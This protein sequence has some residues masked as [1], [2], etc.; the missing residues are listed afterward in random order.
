M[1]LQKQVVRMSVQGG[2]DTKSDEKN[3]L[4]T[5]FLE[6]ENLVTTKTGAFSKRNGFQSYIDDVLGSSTKITSG[7]A[8]AT[9]KDELIRFSNNNVYSYSESQNNWASKGSAKFALASTY[10]VSSNGDK[11]LQPSHDTIQGLTCYVYERSNIV[12]NYIEYKIIDSASG[13][14]VTTNK[15]ALGA[16]PSVVAVVGKFLIFY[17]VGG[18]LKVQAINFST[19]EQISSP[20]NVMSTFSYAAC[21]IGDRAYVVGSGTTGLTVAYVKPDLTLGGPVSVSDTE[22]FNVFAISPEQT[23][24]VRIVYGSNLGKAVKT[25]LLAHDLNYQVHTPTTLVASPATITSLGSVQDPLVL[26]RSQIYI[27]KSDAPY[28][29]RRAVVDNT[30][31]ISSNAILLNQAALQS[32]P[33]SYA[34]KVYFAVSRNNSF[35]GPQPLRTYFLCS[36]DGVFVSKFGESSSVFRDDGTG[37]PNLN[38]EGSSLA[39]MGAEAA[40]LQ[41]I[42]AAQIQ[43]PT[44]V[45]KFSSDFTQT[46]NYFDTTLGDNMHISGGILKMYDGD[47]V[48]EHNFLQIPDAPQLVTQGDGAVGAL[49]QT[50]VY[51]YRCVYKW[52]DKWGQVHRSAPSP[53]L[54]YTVPGATVSKPTIRLLT[55]PFT[56][57]IDVELEVYRTTAS[58]T[59]FF[60]KALIFAEKILNDKSVESITFQD[61]TDNTSIQSTELLYTTGGVLDNL[62][63]QS[64]T[65]VTTYKSR[66]FLILSDGF[67]LQY[68]KKRLQ[69]SPVEFAEEFQ[70]NLDGKG[71]PATA[72]AVLDDHLVVFK[73]DAIFVLTGEGPNDLGEQ[74]DFREPYLITSD[75]GCVDP[76]SVVVTPEGLMFKSAKGIY[77]LRRGFTVEY[78]GAPVERYNNL[79]V[80][81]AT[82]IPNTNEVRFTT[83]G[84]LALVYDYFHKMW[85]TFTNI[86][87]IDATVYKNIYTFMNALGQV[88][89]ETQGIF[90]DSGSYIKT[91]I[92]SSWI[93]L[94]GVQGFQRFYEMMVLG[95]FESEHGLKVEMAFDFNPSLVEEATINAGAILKPDIYGTGLYGQVTPYGGSYPLYQFRIF[96]KR[97][98]CESF[99]FVITDYPTTASVFGAAFT[100]SNFAA[101][102][103]LK[104]VGN[105]LGVSKSFAAK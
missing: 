80:T 102:I 52:V 2:L 32:R 62:S 5:S 24:N 55:L 41:P 35:A 78:V 46:N 12:T 96:P 54:I 27:S 51:Q 25:V 92:A 85:S 39:F 14:V 93:Q 6:L 13:S 59:L 76:N 23:T 66:A 26:G 45:K 100:L 44:L 1:A 82:L 50:G 88:K 7:Q 31:A 28:S 18:T 3:A 42:G 61:T 67:T 9:F 75:C 49:L 97:Q 95:T 57:K 87:G 79:A 37:L 33:A 34:N 83:S 65:F 56:D 98:K 29:L 47:R 70:I 30:G 84:E 60:K 105:K 72:L 91:K 20:V 90:T 94:A 15:F 17:F 101:E 73:Q 36:E 43:V 22:A 86:N 103:G 71:G 77:I 21:R 63:A 74:D 8:V 81:S 53:A 19:P 89:K 16:N 69:R 11:L 64:S 4:A 68:S 58:G 38:L 99:K 48:V 10:S 40:E 104:P